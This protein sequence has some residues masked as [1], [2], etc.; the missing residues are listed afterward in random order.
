[1]KIFPFIEYAARMGGFPRVS[2]YQSSKITSMEDF[3]SILGIFYQEND[4]HFS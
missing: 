4:P 1:V 2:M 3:Q